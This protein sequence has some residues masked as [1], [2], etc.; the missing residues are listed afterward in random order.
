MYVSGLRLTEFRAVS[1]TEIDLVHPGSIRSNTREVPNVSILLGSN[2][3]GKSTV[4]KGIVA[5][6]LGPIIGLAPAAAT[7]P[8]RGTSAECSARAT[9]EL[10]EVDVDPDATFSD[11]TT[12]AT[13]Q[14]GVRISREGTVTEWL[15][16]PSG[17]DLDDTGPAYFLAAYG[18]SRRVTD[19][20]ASLDAGLRRSTRLHR[21]ASLIDD[22]TRLIPLEHWLFDHESTRRFDE[23]VQLVDALLPADVSFEGASEGGEFRYVQRG[24]AVPRAALSDGTQSY[25]AW[26]SDLVMRLADV[27]PDESIA[28]VPGVVLV[29]EVDQRIHPRWQER[30]LS[31][32]SANLP[33]LQFI[34]SAHSP[35]LASALRPENLILMEADLEAPGVGA[36]KA[37]RLREDIFGSTA[38]QV[39]RSS[40]FE[41]ESSRSDVF[42]SE[43]RTLAREARQGNSEAA[44]HFMRML[45]DAGDTIDDDAATDHSFGGRQPIS[46]RGR[47][48]RPPR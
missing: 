27:A 21:V 3:G 45:A 44:L 20:M 17:P 14:T 26:V 2:G 18:P 6:T 22:D 4:L 29:D 23:V 16:A 9:L 1:R 46:R 5:A 42:R 7:W 32:L 47:A 25:L 41:L 19:D 38:D 13:I 40:Y 36:T 28:T 39:L 10:H 8:R 48:G 15:S 34:C 11:E 12:G 31:C 33:S 37:L 43:L 30:M 24:V 35:L